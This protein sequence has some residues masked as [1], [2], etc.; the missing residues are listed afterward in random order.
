MADARVTRM[1]VS[2]A[3]GLTMLAGLG[4]LGAFLLRRDKRAREAEA[5]GRF[6]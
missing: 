3:G 6:Q 4:E 5:D 2:L 1:L